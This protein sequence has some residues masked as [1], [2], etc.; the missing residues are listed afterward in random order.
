MTKKKYA[1]FSKK[2]YTPSEMTR[3]LEKFRATIARIQRSPFSLNE[4][5]YHTVAQLV[6]WDPKCRLIT[7]VEPV[8]LLSPGPS[9]ISPE[10]DRPPA[11]Q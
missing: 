11:P 1:R 7:N 3:A 10:L 2:G 5:M 4:K 6:D 9:N 8:K